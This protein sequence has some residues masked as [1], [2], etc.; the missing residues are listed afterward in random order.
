M[1]QGIDRGLGTTAIN[2]QAQTT[3]PQFSTFFALHIFVPASFSHSF[4]VKPKYRPGEELLFLQISL[5]W[6]QPDEG[7][8]WAEK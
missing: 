5:S 3:L 6:D 2:H 8:V 7:T 4:R 1:L